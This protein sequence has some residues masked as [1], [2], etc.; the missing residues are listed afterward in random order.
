MTD[1]QTCAVTTD[2][3]IPTDRAPF[4]LPRMGEPTGQYPWRCHCLNCG[5][6]LATYSH[7]TMG[8][9][10]CPECGAITFMDEVPLRYQVPSKLGSSPNVSQYRALP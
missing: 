5:K 9:H 10:P 3:W 2:Q 4:P 7:K 6:L 1:Q 8:E